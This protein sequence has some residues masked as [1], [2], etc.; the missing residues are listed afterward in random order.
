MYWF[1]HVDTEK[2]VDMEDLVDEFFMLYLAGMRPP[3]YIIATIILKH[4][5]TFRT[6]ANCHIARICYR[7][8]YSESRHLSEVCGKHFSCL[9]A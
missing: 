5:S 3:C 1:I 8:Y 2:N 7:S 6:G 4:F 9:L